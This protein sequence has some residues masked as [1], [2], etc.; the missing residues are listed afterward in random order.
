MTLNDLISVIQKSNDDK[1]E[2]KREKAC[3]GNVG[4]LD[5]YHI[6]TL[7]IGNKEYKLQST[8]AGWEI[9]D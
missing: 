2:V 7:I 1:I 5:D 9:V 6:V 4:G 8:N 3:H